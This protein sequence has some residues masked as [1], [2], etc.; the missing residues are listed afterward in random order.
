MSV[1]F[2]MCQTVFLYL[3]FRTARLGSLLAFNSLQLVT[4]PGFLR[5]R[6]QQ[7]KGNVLRGQQSLLRIERGM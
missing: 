6:C 5:I 2:A 1:Y 3:T 7:V 4:F